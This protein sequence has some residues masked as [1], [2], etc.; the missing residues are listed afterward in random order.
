MK[1]FIFSSLSDRAM[2]GACRVRLESQGVEAVVVVDANDSPGPLRAGEIV[3][4]FQR[5]GRLFGSAAAIGIVETMRDH[6]GDHRVVCKV[7]ADV[8]LFPAAVRW[9]R[10]ATEKARGFSVNRQINWWGLYAIPVA[11][12]DSVVEMV[13]RIENCDT[14]GENNIIYEALKRTAL[15]AR[16]GADSVQVW[17]SGRVIRP[18][19][20]VLTLPT[21]LGQTARDLECGEWNAV[22]FGE[23]GELDAAAGLDASPVHFHRP[24]CL[25]CGPM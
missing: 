5:K 22:G 21:G 4:D 18:E 15:T 2:A 24:P 13:K 20:I 19:A 25:G 11:A 16:A 17:R 9:M 7:D 8:F 10:E 12:M 6:A 14:C 23:V 1:A 3:T